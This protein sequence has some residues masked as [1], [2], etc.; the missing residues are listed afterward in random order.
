MTIRFVWR[1]SLQYSILINFPHSHAMCE[2]ACKTYAACTRNPK[3]MHHEHIIFCTLTRRDA[4]DPCLPATGFLRDLPLVL[5]VQDTNIAGSC[6]P[7][8]GTTPT[9]SSD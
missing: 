5:D 6:P 1:S 7:C 9:N 3:H 8:A 4:N 2:W